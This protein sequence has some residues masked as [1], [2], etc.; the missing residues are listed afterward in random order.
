MRICVIFNPMARGERARK[1]RRHVEEIGSQCALKPTWAVGAARQLAAESIREGYDTV[2]AAGGDGTL[3]EVLNGLADE[4]AGLQKAR[5]AVLPLGTAN[6]FARELGL[7]LAL[8]A[9]WQIILRGRERRIDLPR[10]E[11]NASGRTECRRFVQLAGVGLDARAVALVDWQLKKRITYL[12]YVA[13]G[14]KALCEKKPAINLRLGSQSF[15]GE[16]VLLGNGRFYGGNFV[17]FPRADLE[18]GL[19]EIRLFRRV[20]WMVFSTC[21]PGVL[22]G[23]R[24]PAFAAQQFQADRVEISAAGEVPLQIDGEYAGHL[25]ALFSIQRQALRVIVP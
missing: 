23:G 17:F 25:P 7:P 3:N 20:N 15:T 5:L 18:D 11:I 12:A 21:L 19:L 8:P 10:V 9:A 13:A 2:V 1:L 4:P 22:L 16:S 24:L 14:F 6:V